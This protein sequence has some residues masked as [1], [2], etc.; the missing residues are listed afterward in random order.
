MSW[1]N[2]PTNANGF[3]TCSPEAFERFR[4]HLKLLARVRLGRKFRGKVD[5]DDLV[6]ETF[7]AAVAAAGDFRG[8]GDAQL[9]AWLR[10]ILT[11][12][13]LKLV[14]RFR[15]GGRDV[16]KERSGL[17]A[18]ANSSAAGWI[19][20]ADQSTPSRAAHRRETAELVAETLAALPPDYREV[21]VLR[22]IEGLSFPEVAA[23][24]GRTVGAVTMLWA[25]AVHQF[26]IVSPTAL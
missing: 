13:V 26:R 20:A 10:A 8:E 9:L 24:M 1:S 23:R 15:A 12:R 7:L 4:P 18:P 16:M 22:N 6:Q 2:G 19:P 21:L 25:R 14:E 5:S 11:S 17:F 3:T